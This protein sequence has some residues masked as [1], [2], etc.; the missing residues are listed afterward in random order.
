MKFNVHFIPICILSGMLSV[1]TLGCGRANDGVEASRTDSSPAASDVAVLSEADKMFLHEAAANSVKERSAARV[2]LEKSTDG[3]VK[4]YA[5]MLVDDHTAALDD[6]VRLMEKHGIRQPADLPE[7]QHEA[8]GKLNGLS[9]A[10]LDREFINTMVQDHQAAVAKFQQEQTTAHHE[11]VR[12]YAKDLLPT[13]EKHLK[14]AQE[15]QN[16]FSA[17]AKK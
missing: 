11:A 16:K 1:A 9:G 5:D 10:A 13:L 4:D 3:D 6:L 17:P 15:L 8:V 14:E 7:A 12:E 2:A